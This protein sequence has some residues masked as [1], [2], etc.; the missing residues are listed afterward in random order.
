MITFLPQRLV[1]VHL[2]VKIDDLRWPDTRRYVGVPWDDSNQPITFQP[3]A[4]PV[5]KDW[6]YGAAGGNRTRMTFQPGDF[7]SPV[8]T[9]ST[10]AANKY[11]K[12]DRIV[13]LGGP[14]RNWTAVKGFADPCLTARPSDHRLLFLCINQPPY[15]VP[16][17]LLHIKVF[18]EYQISDV[19]STKK[20]V[21]EAL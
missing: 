16:T 11:D 2:F 7:K 5:A 15:T 21:N 14:R 12:K 10:T 8:S 1:S 20:A 13:N 19:T 4:S 17:H 3:V 9:N 18:S 6:L